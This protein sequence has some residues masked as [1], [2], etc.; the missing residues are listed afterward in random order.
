M[1]KIVPALNQLGK[2]DIMF[3]NARIYFWILLVFSVFALVMPVVIREKFTDGALIGPESYRS[4]RIGNMFREGYFSYDSLS[5]GGKPFVEEKAWYF[6]ISIAPNFMVRLLPLIFGILSFVLFYFLIDKIN[7]ELKGISS[8]L[9]ILSPAYLY[10]FSTASKYCAAIFFILLG[11]YFFYKRFRYLSIAAFLISGLFSMITLFF[12]VLT[13]L[14]YGLRKE[15]LRNFYLLFFGFIILFILQFYIIFKFGLPHTIFSFVN[16][17]INKIFSFVVFG[18][19]GKYGFN[20]FILILAFIGIYKNFNDKYKYLL[21]YILLFFGFII[22]F[23]MPFLFSYLSFV[24]AY[25]ASLGLILLFSEQWKSGV[26]KFFTIVVI[27]CGILFSFLVFYNQVHNFE[28]NINYAGGINFLKNKVLD[29]TVLSDYRLSDYV[30]YGGERTVIGSDVAYAPN[31][32]ERHNDMK[33]LFNITNIDSALS[34]IDEYNINYIL[35][36]TRMW[37]EFF[38]NHEQGLLFLL[39]Y[40]PNVFVSVF[41]SSDVNIWYVRDKNYRNL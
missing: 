18:I 13:Y 15:D 6:L 5:Y 10:L 12:V 7:P 30:T 32:F 34:L 33:V 31:I 20:F 9:L 14:I 21:I 40:T 39:K 4:I 1:R 3:L 38:D 22:S 29:G 2:G 24:M 19:G 11:F 17:D 41:N 35:V 26:F 36:D 8:L 16:F 28:P 25:F 37:E 23:Y 27:F